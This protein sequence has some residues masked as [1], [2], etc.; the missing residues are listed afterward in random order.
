MK[1][2]I[3]IQ[4]R[5]TSTRFP[6]KVFQKI[7]DK[8]VLQHVLDTAEES[9]I[10]INKYFPKNNVRVSSCLLVPF[11]DEIVKRY[12]HKCI[13]YQGDEHDVLSRYYSMNQE[14]KADYI[15]RI[16]SDCPLLPSYLISKHINIAVKGL[17]DYVSN[18]D[19]QIRT[20]PDG[21]DVEV[22]SARCLDWLNQNAKDNEREHVTLRI[23]HG[24]IPKHFKIA[25]VISYLDLSGI[26]ISF[27]TPEDFENI[28]NEYFRVKKCISTA[29]DRYGQKSIY[30]V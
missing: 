18:V 22:V 29:V 17:Y 10:Y 15:V 5:S 11:N 16:T 14:M 8:E 20:S 19:E 30:R 23:R 13:I 9:C 25:H 12:S 7:D 4:A 2:I 3:A 28:K 27:D 26:K 24:S 1:V 6:G 21:H